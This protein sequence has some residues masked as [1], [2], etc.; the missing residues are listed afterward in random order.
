MGKALPAEVATVDADGTRAV[1]R[2]LAALAR[3]GDLLVL[4]GELGAGK[5]TLAQGIGS[6]LAVRGE[7]T[8]PTFVISR[9][10]PP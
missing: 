8:S 1:G 3:P 7:V 2:R 6:G 5:T 9:V 4:T 10:H